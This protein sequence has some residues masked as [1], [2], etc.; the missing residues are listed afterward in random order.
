MRIRGGPGL[1]RGRHLP[2]VGGEPRVSGEFSPRGPAERIQKGRRQCGLEARLTTPL[3]VSSTSARLRARSGRRKRA[4]R[5]RAAPLGEGVAPGRS[6]IAVA[7]HQEGKEPGTRSGG[8]TDHD[9]EPGE[10]RD[11][12]NTC[13]TGERLPRRNAFTPEHQRHAFVR[14]ATSTPSPHREHRGLSLL[15]S[16]LDSSCVGTSCVETH[17]YGMSCLCAG[18]R[19]AGLPCRGGWGLLGRLCL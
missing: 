9:V 14:P 1:H 10:E 12:V 7:P 8:S 15:F 16:P 5:C 17:R 3:G 19:A 6:D 13:T 18:L 2:R 11:D 4:R